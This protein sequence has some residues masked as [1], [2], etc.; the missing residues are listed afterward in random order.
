MAVCGELEYF[1]EH[2]TIGSMF[3]NP[4]GGVGKH[5]FGTG[6]DHSTSKIARHGYD[7]SI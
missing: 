1:L 7:F 5:N 2:L 6:V 3:L 4:R